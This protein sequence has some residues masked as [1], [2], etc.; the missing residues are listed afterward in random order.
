MATAISRSLR[1]LSKLD[2]LPLALGGLGVGYFL[3]T[4]A[5]KKPPEDDRRAFEAWTRHKKDA[6]VALVFG[7][8]GGALLH[9]AKH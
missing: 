1:S 2:A 7:V 8:A 4:M 9:W 5:A 3:A 6:G